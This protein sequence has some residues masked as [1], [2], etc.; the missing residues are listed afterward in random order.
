M[1]STLQ[2]QVHKVEQLS[3]ALKQYI[4]SIGFINHDNSGITINPELLHRVQEQGPNP[5][6]IAQK[7]FTEMLENIPEQNCSTDVKRIIQNHLNK[8]FE[9]LEDRSLYGKGYHDPLFANIAILL[10]SFSATNK[11][12][13]LLSGDFVNARGARKLIQAVLRQVNRT[14]AEDLFELR[15]I[16]NKKLNYYLKVLAQEARIKLLEFFRA[17][18]LNEN[19]VSFLATPGDEMIILIEFDKDSTLT[20]K[21]EFESALREFLTSLNKDLQKTAESLGFRTNEHFKS[22]PQSGFGLV[23]GF[24]SVNNEEIDACL[25]KIESIITKNKKELYTRD[26]LSAGEALISIDDIEDAKVPTVI[27]DQL[28]QNLQAIP[29]II[30]DTTIFNE[31]H[32][33]EKLFGAE[34]CAEANELLMHLDKL[35]KLPDPNTET[36]TDYNLDHEFKLSLEKAQ[37]LDSSPRLAFVVGSGLASFIA[38]SKNLGVGYVKETSK[39]IKNKLI[40]FGYSE[41]QAAKMIFSVNA[42]LFWILFHGYDENNQLIDKSQLHRL[43][44]R[45][46]KEV[47]AE[48]RKLEDSTIG[49]LADR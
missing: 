31:Y 24:D 34:S 45:F 32:E 37:K 39:I 12:R 3:P 42:T 38:I 21:S 9:I 10:S 35:I 15:D 5:I 28:N 4:D 11:E 41:K 20:N 18:D 46:T 29:E 33:I 44:T 43:E 14:G 7:R 2:N 19:N 30:P 26:R 16:A 6:K 23:L 25:E 8:I 17:H 36:Y 27:T 13:Y 22:K 40:E 47:Q 1:I 48:I 49:E